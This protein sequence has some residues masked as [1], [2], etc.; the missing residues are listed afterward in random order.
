[1]LR[2]TRL[3]KRSHPSR[4]CGLKFDVSRIAG[5]DLLVAPFAGVWIEIW[6]SGSNG[7]LG[8]KVAPFAGVWIEIH[9]EHFL[10]A[11]K[12]GSHPSRV[13]GLKSCLKSEA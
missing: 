6:E 5:C 9:R 10:D 8:R 7:T 2:E 12:S 11:E 3:L 1:M 13:C 4:V